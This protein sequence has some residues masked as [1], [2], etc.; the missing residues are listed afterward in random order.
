MIV[1]YLDKRKPIEI[2]TFNR[3]VLLVQMG[4]EV[5]IL[6]CRQFFLFLLLF[7]ILG[8][9]ASFAQK[10]STVVK[11]DVAPLSVKKITDEDLK[12]YE[13]DPKFDYEIVKAESSWWDDFKTWIGNLFLRFF[14]W[15]FGVDEAAGILV[16]F[17][18]A[19]PYILLAILL[20]LLIKFFLSVNSR[21]PVNMKHDGAFVSLSE[22]EH[23]I[24]N[25]DIEELIQRA[26]ADKN[27]RLAIRYYYLFI[28]QLMSDKEL[29][30]WETQKTNHDYLKEIE[31]PNLKQPFRKITRLYDYIWY[32]DF[33]IDE[34]KYTKAALAFSSLKKIVQNE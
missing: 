11:Y 25:E 14:E 33:S 24:K 20:F 19:L 12:K 34:V 2:L 13:N 17:L 16:I 15:I 21:A 26:L 3:S 27:Y 5:I 28:L 31:K 1:A 30:Y 7:L 4:Y 8:S 18:K 6:K 23:I 29:I 22:E 10:D 9:A 32:G